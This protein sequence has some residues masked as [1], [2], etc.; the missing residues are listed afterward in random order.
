MSF[1]SLDSIKNVLGGSWLGRSSEQRRAGPAIEG[2]STDSRAVTEGQVFLALKGETTD[3]HLYL[4]QAVQNGAGLLIIDRAEALPADIAP[5]VT[6]LLVPDTGAALL[7]LAAAYRRTLESTRVI[8]VAGSNGKTTTVKLIHQALGS[9]LKG[10][11]SVKSFNNAI[12]VPLT[13]LAAK[14]SDQY[15]VCEVGTNAPGEIATLAAV[16][17]PDIAV[18]TSIGREHLEGLKSLSGVVQEEVSLLANL[19]PGGIAVLNAEAPQLLEA[20]RAMLGNRTGQSILSFGFAENADLRITSVTQSEHG[21]RF[22]LNSRAWF[23]LPLL[24]RHN[25]G[26]AAAA[27]AVAR[28]LGVDEAAAA[29]AL[30]KAVGPDMR[31][32]RSEVGGVTFINDAYNANPESMIAAVQTFAEVYGGAPGRRVL[33]LGDMLELGDAAPDLHREV[34]DAVAAVPGVDLA[35]F[36]GRLAMFM[37]ERVN[38]TH[39]KIAILES[40][41]GAKAAEGAALLR[42]GDYVL[43]KGSRRMALER[44]IDAWRATPGLIEP[45]PTTGRVA[46]GNSTP[47]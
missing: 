5:Y 1:W 31:M 30:A 29:A 45:R 21:L 12:G 4:R 47:T 18:I 17:E 19:R 27:V 6:A 20:A 44:I 32:Q 28:R 42:P 35:V 13:I 2:L 43:L 40:L 37:A 22:C 10:S 9:V 46:A 39:A 34:G 33:V 26:N 25:A 3:G 41:D 16:V 11:A 36:V 7:K 38:R 8:A 14:K 15:L 23:D 24:G